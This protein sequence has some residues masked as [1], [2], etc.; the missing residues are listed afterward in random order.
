MKLQRPRFTIGRM[1]I[2]IAVLAIDFTLYKAL[3][4]AT[5]STFLE[6]TVLVILYDVLG[7]AC[8]AAL[9]KILWPQADL[10]ILRSREILFEDEIKQ[11]LEPQRPSVGL[12]VAAILVM[13]IFAGFPFGIAVAVLLRGL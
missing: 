9:K 12:V 3:A 7:A 10:R 6:A 11:A 1:M 5:Y 2:A 4:K 8:L 13:V